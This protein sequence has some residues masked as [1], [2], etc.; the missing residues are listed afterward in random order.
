[1]IAFGTLPGGIRVSTRSIR[2]LILS[3]HTATLSLIAEVLLTGQATSSGLRGNGPMVDIP[4]GSFIFGSDSGETKEGPARSIDLPSFKIM[5]YEVTNR[6]YNPYV[7]ATGR[8]PSFYS[9][10]PEL[11]RDDHPVVGVSWGDAD[12]FCRHFGLR[13]PTEEQ[14]ERAAR[15][16]DGR[17]FAWGNDDP[18]ARR[19]NRGGAD[20]C[21][22]DAADGYPATAPVGSFGEG[23]TPEGVSDM[24]GNVWEWVDGWFNSYGARPAARKK[25]FRV[26]RG[27]A[28]NSDDWKL[29]TTYRL[30][31]ESDF[32]FAANAGFRCVT[33][34]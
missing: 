28:W 9:S 21:M 4:G 20:C 2:Y 16:T 6:Q 7:D 22:P 14:W 26:A 18:T 8:Q 23:D 11:G 12:G 33:S 32:R 31:Y 3:R 30:A 27:G 24:T 10:H 1:M 25:E 19:A 15:G 34:P 13:L 17:R 5:K 29:R